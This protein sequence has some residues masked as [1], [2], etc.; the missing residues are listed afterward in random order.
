MSDIPPGRPA[1]AR[2]YQD[3]APYSDLEEAAT[4]YL[5]DPG[6]VMQSLRRVIDMTSIKAFVMERTVEQEGSRA[7]L[8]QEVAVTD[9]R[10]LLLWMGNDVVADE[11]DPEPGAPLFTSTVRSIPLSAFTDRILKIWYRV[12]SAGGQSL[13]SVEFRLITPSPDHAI[14]QTPSRTEIYGDELCFT[15]S[16]TDGGR[17]QMERLVQFGRVVTAHG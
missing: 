2:E 3:W 17:A 11:D 5:R 1:A 4:A 12:G 6:I 7:S 15:K 16:V 8:Y 14:A 13:H 10:T 9:G